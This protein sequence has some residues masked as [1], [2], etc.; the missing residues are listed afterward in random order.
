MRSRSLRLLVGALI[1]GVT[2]TLAVANGVGASTTSGPT[3]LTSFNGP[4][5][6]VGGPP[7]ATLAAGPTRVVELVNSQFSIVDRNG[8]GATGPIR[9]L[10]GA[11]SSAFLS[12]PQVTWDPASN[13]FFFS[14]F[15]NRGGSTP[16]EGI[17]WGF[18]K[19]G[20]PDTTSDWCQYFNAFNYGSAAFPDR[21]SLGLTRNF[22]MFVSERFSVP[23][24]RQEHGTTWAG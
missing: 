17:A 8:V 9:D 24:A 4:D 6:P 13:R 21:P 5:D 10:V 12:D 14:I 11:T 20:S 23:V 2:L 18:S 19:S 16:D 7:D 1:V 22:V 3:L 15:E